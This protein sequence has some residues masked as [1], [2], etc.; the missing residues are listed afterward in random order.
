[1]RNK[2]SP[3]ALGLM[4]NVA[5]HPVYAETGSSSIEPPLVTAKVF[6]IKGSRAFSEGRL[7]KLV[8]H[9][10]GRQLTR[11]ELI[12]LADSITSYYR[13]QG[14]PRAHAV[15][16]PQNFSDGIVNFLVTTAPVGERPKPE[17]R[18]ASAL[19]ADVMDGHG[20]GD[21]AQMLRERARWFADR[22]HVDLALE[23]LDK[24]FSVAPNDPAGLAMRAQLEIQYGK[25]QEAQL[26]LDALR[27][28]QPNH[29]SIS[30]VESLLHT[31]GRD[32][33]KLSQARALVKEAVLLQEQAGQLRA[34]GKGREANARQ[35]QK[36]TRYQK[37]IAIFHKLFPDGPPSGDLALEYWGM[38]AR[39]PHGWEPARKGIARLA[40]D[41]PGNLRYRLA[42][43]EHEASRLPLKRHVLQVIIDISKDPDYSKQARQAWRSVLLRLADTPAALPLLRDYLATEANDS[44]VREKRVAI[45]QAQVKHRRLLADPNYQAQSAGLAHLDNDELDAAEP[46]LQQAAH[47]R[48]K[49]SEAVGG[50]G[51]LRLRQGRH[52]EAK[53]Y[54]EQAAHLHGDNRK[55]WNSLIK[56][57]SF[58][59]LMGEARD[60]RKAGN[61]AL[62]EIKLKAALELDANQVDA[63]VA[64]ADLQLDRGLTAT[65]VATYRRAL[66]IDPLSKGALEGLLALYLQQENQREAQR[67]LEQLSPAQRN[68][69]GATLPRMEAKMLQEQ[70]G[71]LLENG[72]DEA[73]IER[74][75][76]AVNL[77]TDDPWL[78]FSLANLYARHR[79]PEKGRAL[80]DALLARQP[81]DAESLYALA[82]FQTS[83]SQSVD[84]LDTLSRIPSEQ[85]SVKTNQLLIRNWLQLANAELQSGRKD[86]AGRLLRDAEAQ[87]GT[88]EESGLAVAIFWGKLGEYREADRVFSRQRTEPPSVR[89]RMR[90]A[91]YLAMREAPELQAELDSIASMPNMSANDTKEIGAMQESLVLRIANTQLDA[92]QYG[93]AHNTLAPWLKKTPERIPLLLAD[94]QI[95]WA[96][97]QFLQAS[98]IFSDV[99]RIDPTEPEARRGLVET[100]VAAGNRLEALDRL[101]RWAVASE[102]ES[103]LNRLQLVELYLY[104]DEPGSAKRLHIP[105]F[106]QHPDHPRVLNQAWQIAQRENRLDEQ[107]VYM[108]K[109]LAAEQADRRATSSQAET[110]PE[111]SVGFRQIGFDELG[112]PEK[113]R[114]DWQEKKL[115][116]LIDRRGGWM[117]AAIDMRSRVGTSGVSQLDSTE[118]PL[119]YRRP[120]HAS[121]EIIIRTDY[122]QLDAGR[123]AA[124][125]PDF[126]GMLLCKPNC[127]ANL[128]A[129][130]A[131]GQSFALGY[132]SD[133]LRA[134]IGV[135]PSSFAVS[136]VVGGI[137]RGGD[138]GPFSYSLEASRRPLTG[139]LLSFAGT[140]DPNTGRVWGGVV[141]TGVDLGI[142]LDKGETF[143]FWSSFGLHQLTGTNVLDNNRQQLM[144][145]ATSRIVN[146]ENRL[147]S[148]GLTGM[149][150]HHV[151]NSGEY[152]FGH[153]GYYS[154]QNYLSLS[155]PV[156]YGKRYPRFSYVL[157]GAVSVS[158]SK[159]Q[160][161]DYYPTDPASQAQ[162]AALSTANFVTPVYTGGSSSGMGYS[163]RVSWEY[164]LASPLFVGGLLSIDR[165]DNYTPNRALIFLR[166]S[167]DRPAA[168]P[169]YFP[170]RP[171]EPSSQL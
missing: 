155:L 109:A 152:T 78:N 65:A 127:A 106:V 97:N 123:V 147:F 54:F 7:L 46:L 55:K 53:E 2:L 124:T 5:W 125:S 29:P 150:W 59:Q 45:V 64:V 98:A 57:A 67:T 166:Y 135:T 31:A 8:E 83:Q 10:V 161:A 169:V 44:A 116:A 20:S 132:H 119:E 156:T 162:A 76:A 110:P 121:D 9:S 15:I 141:A 164:Q 104:L 1:V 68:A 23:S 99:L 130:S 138:I 60:A 34:Q 115:A 95:Y 103:L 22:D 113:I 154:P 6:H 28:V 131:S 163:L 158:Q 89:W 61:L 72:Q 91:E 165:S 16:P 118:V 50:M 17:K 48:P 71:H 19:A 145:G 30:R 14:F 96:E 35:N 56:V 148:L 39:T 167:L 58:W 100:Q 107:I 160:S 133:D 139:S 151:R 86:D 171:V 51:M 134:D 33:A 87:A 77:N 79:Q 81:K 102:A 12:E 63:I 111:N 82:L 66:T 38:V 84:A 105:L 136:N 112:S 62:A 144:A 21:P 11:S 88:D 93:L 128:L 90:H 42:L 26:T 126:G 170:P 4:L 168:Q 70:S 37:A 80:F 122:V 43:A 108:Q 69:L 18:V 75:E 41:N 49:D 47:A 159:T 114:R 117:S 142:G 101:D 149:Y 74:L 36:V 52:R 94:A 129:Q 13:Q 120:W 137:R 92:G 25:L 27:R 153:G 24:L 146:E 32:K 40:R 3:L 140:R 143:G 157:R 85:R 73:A